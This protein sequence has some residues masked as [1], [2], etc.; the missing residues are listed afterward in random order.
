ME[1]CTVPSEVLLDSF[2][3]L[4]LLYHDDP[5]SV[6]DPLP[7]Q[8]HEAF[9]VTYPVVVDPSSQNLIDFGFRLPSAYDNRPLNF[10]EFYE[11]VNQAVF[12]SATPGEFEK[13]VV[14]LLLKMGYGS[15]IDDGTAFFLHHLY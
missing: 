1:D 8:I 2:R 12:V 9:H 14:K 13:L 10:D 3:F 15:G 7:S 5:Y 11:K 6:P 4:P